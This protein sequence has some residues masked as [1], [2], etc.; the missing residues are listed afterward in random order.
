M[1]L[2]AQRT[3]YIADGSN[4]RVRKV[5]GQDSDGDGC[6]DAHELGANTLT[7]GNRDPDNSWDFFD[8]PEPALRAANTSGT[9]SHTVSL[10]DVLGVLFYVGTTASSPSQTNGNGVVYGSDLNGNGVV[11]GREYDRTLPDSS[12]PWLS[13]PPNGI[14]SIAD[15]ITALNQ[16]GANCN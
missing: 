9:L 6:S 16:V 3:L 15:A 7:G 8:T 10:A 4:N 14:V 1:T 13:G 5:T 12:K 11:D 2:D